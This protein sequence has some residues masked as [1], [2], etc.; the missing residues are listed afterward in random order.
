MLEMH[1]PWPHLWL[2]VSRIYDQGDQRTWRMKGGE[3]AMEKAI[4]VLLGWAAVE[5]VHALIT[6][7]EELLAAKIIRAIVAAIQGLNGGQQRP[8]WA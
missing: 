7:A 5:F 8:G 4:K 6:Q 3:R 2:G 1:C